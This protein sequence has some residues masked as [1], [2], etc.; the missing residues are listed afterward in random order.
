MKNLT[1]IVHTAEKKIEYKDMQVDHLMPLKLGGND[2]I[3]NLM[4]TC[5]MCNHYKRANPLESWR[6]MIEKIPFKL[7]RDSYIY[8]VGLQ[9]G[10][11]V[12]NYKK[13]EFYFE[14]VKRLKRG[15]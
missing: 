14:E 5:R 12:T 7:E 2:D 13:I 4:P 15:E 10:N 6:K 9:F 8:R 11:V 3:K 1:V